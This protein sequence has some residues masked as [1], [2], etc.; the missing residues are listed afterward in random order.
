MPRWAS[1][2]DRRAVQLPL[3]GEFDG[4][5][6][7]GLCVPERG[8]GPDLGVRG[9]RLGAHGVALGKVRSRALDDGALGFGGIPT[10]QVRSRSSR[11]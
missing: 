5:V 9:L 4:L 2:L 1:A 11:Q 7:S 10:Y 3:D 8:P 6:R